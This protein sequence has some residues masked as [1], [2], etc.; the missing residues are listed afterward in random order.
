MCFLNDDESVAEPKPDDVVPQQG[1]Q[2]ISP[3]TYGVPTEV[4]K[5]IGM[6]QLMWAHGM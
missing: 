5:L 3:V 1:L 6:V 4:F 2:C